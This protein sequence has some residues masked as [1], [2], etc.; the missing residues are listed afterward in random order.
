MAV[1][2][3][4]DVGSNLT[5]AGLCRALILLGP[6]G[7]GKGTQ[8]KQI[9]ALLS[10]PHLS[11]GD[12]FRDHAARG[13]ELG[14]QAAAIMQTGQLVPDEIVNGMVEER[15]RR[16]DCAQGFLL[17]G[18]PRTV[19][20]AGALDGTLQELFGCR[21][22]VINLRVEYNELIQ[23][24]TGR[25]S[26][27]QCGAIYNLHFKPPAR[28]GLCD[29]EEAALIQRADDQEEVVRDRI[30]AYDTL[31]RPLVDYYRKREGFYE[32]D[33]GQQPEAI[34]RQIVEVLQGVGWQVG[35]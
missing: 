7:A 9:A 22:V 34:T 5:K 33:G 23:R 29:V 4:A 21:P 25:R 14:K 16:P 32:V 12:M 20:Q 1:Q 18:Y 11:T 26:C 13:T 35:K 19:G 10:V 30:S 3:A 28:P 17:D 15:L 8:A 6:P 2:N 31:T 24:L 27:P